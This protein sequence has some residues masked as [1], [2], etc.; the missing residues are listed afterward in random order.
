MT[1]TGFW[2]GASACL[3]MLAP[4]AAAAD[5]LTDALA[6]PC[7]S[8][9]YASGT[10]R[11]TTQDLTGSR[12]NAPTTPSSSSAVG[13]TPVVSAS[14]ESNHVLKASP[15]NLYGVYATTGATAGWY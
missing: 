11:A 13:I 10:V 15:G 3:A 4:C 6:V 5:T 2:L 14:L 1:R 9:S 7:G 8:M 12:C